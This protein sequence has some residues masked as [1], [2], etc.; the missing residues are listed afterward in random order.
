MFY[1]KIAGEVKH[2]R[3]SKAHVWL[4]D[5]TACAVS[6]TGG[7]DNNTYIVTQTSQGKKICKNCLHVLNLM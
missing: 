2:V 3:K 4:G 5:D 7:L 6:S 1:I